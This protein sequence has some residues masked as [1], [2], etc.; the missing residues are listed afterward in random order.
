M[1][2][3][4]YTSRDYYSIREDLL[5]RAAELPIGANWNTRS[6]SDFGVMLVDLW[7]YM[8]DVLH[9]YVDRAAAET[10]IGTATQRESVVALANLLD[11]EPLPLDSSQATVTL[12]STSA[13]TGPVVIPAYTSFV[14]PNRDANETTVYYVSTSSASMAASNSVVTIP[15]IEG[16]YVVDEEPT[17]VLG[18][19]GNKSNGA[20]NQKFNLRYANVLKSN[21]EVN[22]FEGPIDTEGNP[23]SVPYRYVTRLV[24]VASFEQVFTITETADNTTQIVFGNG[25]N[26]KIPENG[27]AITV[28]Y[29]RSVGAAGNIVSNRITSFA[30]NTP[31]GVIVQ[32]STAAVGGYNQESIA[33]MKANIPLLFRT[34]D[35]AVSLQDFKDLSLRI[36]GVVKATAT[37]T[38]ATVNLFPI[39]F[40]SD[41]L[42]VANSNT[43]SIPSTLATSTINYFE[44]RKMVGASVSVASSITLTP[45]YIKANI[46]VLDG[47]VQRWVRDE[48]TATLDNFFEF[49]A[50]S[51]GQTLSLGEI[52]RA[53]MNINGVDYVNIVTFNTSNSGIASGNKITASATSLLRKGLAYD[54]DGISGGVVGA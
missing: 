36:P 1:T 3:F 53:L 49:D 7:A 18:T 5:S 46:T 48:A 31:T 47:Y 2:T 20:S 28:S 42:N 16:T 38:G 15:V 19:F 30:E 4:D 39:E 50:V 14:A 8:G 26:G 43:L 52:Y 24:D 27:A 54:F 29:V 10:F 25:V 44:P 32:S 6:P 51:F 12:V 11:Y 13:F 21:V 34:Q 45:V 40:Q 23:T 22:V 37:N 33:S 35:R 41:Y 9:F 17:N